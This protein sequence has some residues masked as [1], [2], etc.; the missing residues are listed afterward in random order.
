MGELAKKYNDSQGNINNI[1]K[2]RTW[3]IETEYDRYID[4]VAKVKSL[5]PSKIRKLWHVSN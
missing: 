5:L 2:K 1:I 3:R 4:V